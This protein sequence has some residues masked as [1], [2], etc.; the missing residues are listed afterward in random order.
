M[1]KIKIDKDIIIEKEMM[2]LLLSKY[3]ELS[4]WKNPNETLYESSLSNSFVESND[5][6]FDENSKKYF[7]VIDF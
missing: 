7:I 6:N 1:D 3:F 4:K 5:Q 2:N